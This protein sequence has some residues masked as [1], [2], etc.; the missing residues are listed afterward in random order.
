MFEDEQV[1]DDLTMKLIEELLSFFCGGYRSVRGWRV[2]AAFEKHCGKPIKDEQSLKA[3]GDSL[4]RLLKADKI[5][6]N[7]IRGY[8]IVKMFDDGFFDDEQITDDL[9]VKFVEAHPIFCADHSIVRDFDMHY[10][11]AFRDSGDL[12]KIYTSI[13]RLLNAGKIVRT[14]ESGYKVAENV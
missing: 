3:I 1:T 10:H 9:T 13:A 5:I 2:V 6:Y 4:F 7:K 12:I 11:R 8:R 14:E